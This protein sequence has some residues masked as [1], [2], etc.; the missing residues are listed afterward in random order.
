MQEQ[1]LQKYPETSFKVYTVWLPILRRDSRAAIPRAAN[2]MPDERVSHFWDGGK[3]VGKWYK[4]HVLPD[5]RGPTVWDTFFLYSPDATWETVPE[6][7]VE[8]GSTVVGEG[9][10]LVAA[11]EMLM[12]EIE[13]E[14]P[15]R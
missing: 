13:E 14:S 11:F 9:E 6:P 10:L 12:E 4:A 7:L 1:I 15:E 2:L 8:T 5:Y 3:L